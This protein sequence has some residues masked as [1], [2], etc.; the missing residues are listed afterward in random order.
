MSNE[1]LHSLSTV[2]AMFLLG[3]RFPV[4]IRS[5]IPIQETF[6]VANIV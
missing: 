1:I 4:E 3:V 5:L 6:S 2:P